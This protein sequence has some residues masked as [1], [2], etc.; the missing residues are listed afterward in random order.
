MTNLVESDVWEDGIYQLETSDPVLAGPDGVDNLQAKQL[1]NR[2]RFLKEQQAAHAAAADPHTQY[3]TKTALADALAA[4]VNAS[5]ATLDTLN[6]LAT[7]LGDDPNF[8]ATMTNVLALKAALDSPSF[9]GTPKAPTPAQF[10]STTKLATMA[11]LRQAGF[12]ISGIQTPAASTTLDASYA[13]GIAILAA[14]GTYTL[15]LST[16]MPNGATIKFFVSQTGAILARNG[17]DSIN[18]NGTGLASIS[19]NVGD[20]LTLVNQT[21]GGWLAIDGS[22][23]L[24]YSAKFA[25]SLAATGYQ[26]LPSGLIIQ[27]GTTL[28]PANNVVGTITLPIAMPNV[29]LSASLTAQTP[30]GASPI[31]MVAASKSTVSTQCPGVNSVSS[32]YIVIGY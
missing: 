27:W 5:P 21:N 31:G 17:G 24:P 18:V 4:L 9:T 28:V 25:A 7:A 8:A 32:Y 2:T 16:S 13:G 26:K 6:E 30:P 12:Q 19:L 3:A 11:A 20:H 22:G 10:D 14:A 1:A 23:Q 15:P 29:I